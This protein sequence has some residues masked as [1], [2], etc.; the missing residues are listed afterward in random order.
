[1]ALEAPASQVN[2]KPGIQGY[3]EELLNKSVEAR[4]ETDYQTWMGRCT[5]FTWVLPSG[6]LT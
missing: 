6:Y 4:L 2:G 3:N 1:M 5:A